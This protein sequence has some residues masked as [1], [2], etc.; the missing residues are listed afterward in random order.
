MQGQVLAIVG[1][2]GSGKTSLLNVIMAEM[3]K[4]HGV[5]AVAALHSGM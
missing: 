3:I 2:V 5:V 1:R 4:I